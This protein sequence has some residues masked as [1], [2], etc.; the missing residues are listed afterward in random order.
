MNLRQRLQQEHILY[1]FFLTSP[2]PW[3]AEQF[4]NF[5]FESLTLDMQHS[6][7]ENAHLL[8]LLQAIKAAGK[9]PLI[10]LNWNR[11]D[12]IMKALDYGIEGLI[13]PMIDNAKEAAAFVQAAKYPPLGNRSFGPIRA[14]I[15]GGADYF[16]NA[17]S[18]TLTFA[19]IETKGAVGDL[20]AIAATPGLDGLYIG[21][22]DLSVSMGFPK[23]ADFSDPQLLTL[24]DRIYKCARN[25]NLFT[26]IFTVDPKDAKAMAAKGFD[27]VTCG[28]DGI[29]LRQGMNQWE[30]K[31]FG[32]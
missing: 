9:L 20:E 25:N 2:S 10:R 21:P 29:V 4:S 16:Q 14:G 18:N 31:L 28:T 1:N 13:C 3:A 27:I 26:A 17:N 30:E 19:M 22:F 8:A 23:K 7:I 24:I 6:L 5:H 32:E 12:L 15:Y 11:P